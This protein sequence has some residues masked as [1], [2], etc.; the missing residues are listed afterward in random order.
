MLHVASHARPKSIPGRLAISTAA[1]VG[2]GMIVATALAGTAAGQPNGA[3]GTIKIDGEPFNGDPANEPHVVCNFNLEFFGF[4]EDE[5]ADITFAAQPPT[6]TGTLLAQTDVLI[7][8]DPAGGG[9][10]KDAVLSYTFDDLNLGG[11]E[12]HPQQGFHVK[13]TVD[14]IDDPGAGKHKVFWIKPCPKPKPTKTKTVA[15]T[16]TKTVTPTKTKTTEAPTATKTTTPG[17][18]PVTGTDMSGLYLTGG[19]LIAA[20]A[21]LLLLGWRWRRRSDA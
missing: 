17:A 5:R 12:P 2:A 7:S 21:T 18:L 15:P 3:S 4:G 13:V 11:F 19:G 1:L 8:D 6:G 20:G 14:V 16:K 9:N 10:D